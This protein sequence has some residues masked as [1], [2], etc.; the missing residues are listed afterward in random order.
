MLGIYLGLFASL[1]RRKGR[2]S[3]DKKMGGRGGEEEYIPLWVG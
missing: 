2:R 1:K 3:N